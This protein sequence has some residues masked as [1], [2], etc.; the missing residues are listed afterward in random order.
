MCASTDR[1]VKVIKG[2]YVSFLQFAL[3]VSVKLKGYQSR[4]RMKERYN[5]LERTGK[6]FKWLTLKV[7]E[8]MNEGNIVVLS[9]SLSNI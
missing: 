6:G 5:E 2:A 4:I 1:W 9:G 8:E 7:T 3:V